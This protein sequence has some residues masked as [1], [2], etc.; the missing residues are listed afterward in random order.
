MEVLQVDNCKLFCCFTQRRTYG[1]QGRS[2]TRTNHFWKTAQSIV[3]RME[4]AQG[5]HITIICVFFV[6]LVSRCTEINKWRKKF[7]IHSIHSSKNGWIEHHVL[8]GVQVNDNFFVEDLL[9]LNILLY[10]IDFVDQN[11]IGKIARRSVQN[12]ENTVWLLR[13]NKHIWYV[14]NINAVFQS[15]GRPYCNTF[16]RRTFS[17][18]RHM[19]T[20]SKRVK[21]IYPM[22]FY[23]TEVTL[24]DKL[25]FFELNTLMSKH[26]SKT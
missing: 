22:K 20:C 25:D 5:N 26:F 6:L 21:K 7:Q 14:N 15:F 24:F 1:V 8:Q 16:F 3:S 18:E 9:T 4:K 17:L 2:L 13:C 23:Q 19:T 11:I 12:Y 10:D